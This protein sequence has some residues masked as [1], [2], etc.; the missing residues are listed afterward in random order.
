MKGSLSCL[1]RPRKFNNTFFPD[2][3]RFA[4]AAGGGKKNLF[5]QLWNF[6]PSPDLPPPDVPWRRS[7]KVISLCGKAWVLFVALSIHIYSSLGGVGI[8]WLLALDSSPGIGSRRPPSI[9]QQNRHFPFCMHNFQFLYPREWCQN[10][11]R[12]WCGHI[13]RTR[14]SD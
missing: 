7:S 14:V 8:G 10:F 6:S 1:Y 4:A 3:V 2:T 11:R 9:P 13:W 5:C 12:C